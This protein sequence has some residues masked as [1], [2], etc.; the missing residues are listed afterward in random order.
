[1]PTGAAT[2]TSTNSITLSAYADTLYGYRFYKICRT[3][4]SG[5]PASTGVIATGAGK[6]FIDTGLSG[7]GSTCA[8]T[9]AS[10]TTILSPLPCLASFSPGGNSM[11]GAPCGIDAPP[12]SPHTIDDEMTEQFGS[13]GDANNPFWTQIN[14]GAATYTWTGGT[15]SIAATGSSADSLRCM[16][17]AIP[18]T[19]FGIVTAAYYNTTRTGNV[20]PMLAFRESATGKIVAI[21]A[22]IQT[23]GN[24]SMFV[25]SRWTSPTVN[26]VYT[27]STVAMTNYQPIYLK[28]GYD[29][30]NTEYQ[31]SPDGLVYM[32]STTEAK[33]AFFTTAP[34]QVGVCNDAFAGTSAVE[35]DYIRQVAF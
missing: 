34:D 1:V 13:P 23:A 28:V 32:T 20:M 2:I 17:H 14:P 6:S 16:F 8:T 7:D 15:I 22:Q 31:Y 27:P 5:T 33:N 25:Y 3:A 9:Y 35:F 29:G 30:T 18:S 10:N 26:S 4:S 12:L 21:S 24:S 11:P 19:P